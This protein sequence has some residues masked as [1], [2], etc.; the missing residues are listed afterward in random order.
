[1][2][3]QRQHRPNYTNLWSLKYK[4]TITYFFGIN[5]NTLLYFVPVIASQLLYMNGTKIT[6]INT[7]TATFSGSGASLT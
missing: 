3:Y 6:L 4:L 1:M 2:L 7:I 5:V